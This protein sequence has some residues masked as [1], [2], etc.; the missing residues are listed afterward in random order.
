MILI[1]VMML[2]IDADS[3]DDELSQLFYTIA[4]Q[5]VDPRLNPKVC[6]GCNEEEEGDEDDNDDNSIDDSDYDSTCFFAKEKS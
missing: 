4:S 6:E 2:V 3:D 1:N 5:S